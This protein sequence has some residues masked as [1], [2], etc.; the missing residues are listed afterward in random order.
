MLHFWS[1]QLLEF[2]LFR[3][4]RPHV[5]GMWRTMQPEGR[6][7]GCVADKR[8]SRTGTYAIRLSFALVS[9]APKKKPVRKSTGK[10]KRKPRTVTKRKRAAYP[11]PASLLKL[12]GFP[13]GS[14]WAISGALLI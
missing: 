13:K 6:Q 8:H 3:H 7:R 14:P 9:M 1:L 2:R 4:I 5:D 12:Q 10:A 11:T